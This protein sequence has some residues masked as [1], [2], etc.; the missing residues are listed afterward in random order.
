MFSFYATLRTFPPSMVYLKLCA[1]LLIIIGSYLTSL[2]GDIE[3]NVENPKVVRF[4][5]NFFGA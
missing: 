2:F 3:K 5:L 4:H 1:G